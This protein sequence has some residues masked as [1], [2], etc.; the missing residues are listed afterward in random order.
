MILSLFC[1]P[2]N[3]Q[4]TPHRSPV[5]VL[6]VV[7]SLSTLPNSFSFV[8]CLFCSISC[9]ILPRYIGSLQC[10]HVT[11]TR[12]FFIS[13]GTVKSVRC[14]NG[15]GKRLP[16]VLG[17]EPKVNPVGLN[18]SILSGVR[19]GTCS[20]TTSDRIW[21]CHELKI[22]SVI[23]KASLSECRFRAWSTSVLTLLSPLWLQGSLHIDIASTSN[24][25]SQFIQNARCYCA[26]IGL[27]WFTNFEV[28]LITY[29]SSD[30]KCESNKWHIIWL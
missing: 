2:N 8:P 4:N 11:L 21:Y 20:I 1:S 5:R 29:T 15:N 13:T 28:R 12:I 17:H 18:S 25:Y 9:Y 19:V 27:L 7:S 26:A 24:C 23:I 6:Y 10:Y 3:S 14:A 22:N 16:I 30:Q